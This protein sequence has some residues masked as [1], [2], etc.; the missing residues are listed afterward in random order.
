MNMYHPD[1]P[2]SP[3]ELEPIMA[4]PFLNLEQAHRFKIEHD[5]ERGCNAV[6][7]PDENLYP[8]AATAPESLKEML[9]ERDDNKVFL[10]K[11]YVTLGQALNDAS[12][13]SFEDYSKGTTKLLMSELGTNLGRVAREASLVP[14]KL[15]YLNIVYSREHEGAKLLP[16]IGFVNVSGETS[17]AIKSKVF[18]NLADSL[19][20]GAA[21]RKQRQLAA[22]ALEA[23][24][25]SFEV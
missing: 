1:K 18:D 20:I 15:S 21:N 3:S 22:V 14:E 6:V 7:L 9:L 4:N 8:D 25:K 13:R 17:Q 12:G 24:G 16:P 10:P 5:T 23:F 19:H 2:G 11:N